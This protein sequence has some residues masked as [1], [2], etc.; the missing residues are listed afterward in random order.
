MQDEEKNTPEELARMKAISNKVVK[1]NEDI[2]TT[3]VRRKDIEILGTIKVGK[4]EFFYPEATL[5]VVDGIVILV[6][7]EK[8]RVPANRDLHMQS[9]NFEGSYF[10]WT[11]IQLGDEAILRRAYRS[12]SVHQNP[13]LMGYTFLFTF[14]I[15]LDLNLLSKGYLSGCELSG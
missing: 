2:Y 6:E 12:W 15:A 1:L 8:G 3:R 5:M 13:T 4:G 10:R 14:C 11:R 9:R 7:H